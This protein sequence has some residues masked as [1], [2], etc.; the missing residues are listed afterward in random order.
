MKIYDVIILGAGASGLMCAA[1][2]DKKYKVG[3]VDVNS[4]VACKLKISGGGKCN[5]TNVNVSVDNYD[6]DAEFISLS[7]DF[8]QR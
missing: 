1:Y 6:G 8:F 3:A 2:L 5:I 4:K 7:S